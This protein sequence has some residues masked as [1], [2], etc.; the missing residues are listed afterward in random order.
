MDTIWGWL[1]VHPDIWVGRN[2]QGNSLSFSEVEAHQICEAQRPKSPE[3]QIS[4][5]P[6]SESATRV[7]GNSKVNKTAEVPAGRDPLQIFTTID[8]IWQAVAGHPVDAKRI[9]P[10]EFH[11]LCAI[12]TAGESGISQ[13]DLINI[14]GQDK[15]SLPRRTDMLARNGY[16]EK[17]TMFVKHHKT[18][19]LRHKRYCKGGID[20]RNAWSSAKFLEN[21]VFHN[22]QLSFNNLIN[23]LCEQL[24][25]DNIMTINDLHLA[26]ELTEDMKWERKAVWRSLERLDVAGITHRFRART[27]LL[28]PSGRTRYLNCVKLLKVPTEADLKAAHSLS[29]K[30]RKEYRR[31]LEAQKALEAAGKG[32]A[33]V[34]DATQQAAPDDINEEDGDEE[35][36]TEEVEESTAVQILPTSLLANEDKGK[37]PDTLVRP[38]WDP[39][40]PYPNLIQRIVKRAGATGTKMTVS[41]MAF[42]MCTA[43][44][45]FRKYEQLHMGAFTLVHLRPLWVD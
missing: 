42:A 4:E 33:V 29:V 10:M 23:W 37:Q 24:K 19:L 38:E 34:G 28:L 3:L 39:D 27:D 41:L 15:R 12:A 40:L 21:R 18:S 35:D 45:W 9:P 17:T 26:L 7:A 32:K 30:D 20:I 31:K 11:A 22:K 2:R 25:D 43:A 1:T 8:R 6:V 14:T 5:L 16:I 13:P 36:G 44:Y